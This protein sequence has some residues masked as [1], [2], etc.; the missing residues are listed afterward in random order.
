MQ[1]RPAGVAHLHTH[2]E[3]RHL[4]ENSTRYVSSGIL[5]IA[6]AQVLVI[7][8]AGAGIVDVVINF[9]DQTGN[10]PPVV[11]SGDFNP[12]ATFSTTA[13]S[14]LV[15]FS[16]AGVTGTSSPNS[17][18]ATDDPTNGPYDS[19]FFVDFTNPVNNFSFLISSDNDPGTIATLRV[20]TSAS[21]GAPADT[22]DVVG[23]G[24]LSD[25]IPFDLSS[26]ADVTRIEVIN[27]VDKFGLSYDDLSFRTE[28][29]GV[30]EP[31][32]TIS[33]LIGAC[34]LFAKR[35]LTPGC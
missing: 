18:T 28:E 23:N 33:L 12:Y 15:V 35:R 31:S 34:C 30:P 27:I 16:G 21:G 10:I 3:R 4:D 29:I 24:N 5:A 11:N 1:L 9:D 17:M 8:P 14:Q 19:D 6:L 7:S 22:V 32:T 13:G 26:H 25:A 2:L 20:F